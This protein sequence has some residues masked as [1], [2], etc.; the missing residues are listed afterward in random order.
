MTNSTGAN[1]T[2]AQHLLGQVISG[3]V[4]V[5]L[6]DAAQNYTDG[7]SAVSNDSIVSKNIAETAL[8]TN[9]ATGFSDA[10]TITNDND[11]DF[12]VSSSSAT[13]VEVVIQ[14]QN[15]TNRF[16]LADETNDPDLSNLDTW[17]LSSGTTLY[18]LGNPT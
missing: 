12:D 15:N 3:G 9:S 4:T 17:T 2:L 6:V 7:A 13:A 8:T 16:V 5:H 11:V 14:N 1:D 10:A 18:E